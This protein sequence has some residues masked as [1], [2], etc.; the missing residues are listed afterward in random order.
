MACLRLAEADRN[1]MRVELL[2]FVGAGEMNE[3]M[4]SFFYGFRGDSRFSTVKFYI[5]YL[6]FNLLILLSF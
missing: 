1:S 3:V 2:Y 5:L 6:F 4:L